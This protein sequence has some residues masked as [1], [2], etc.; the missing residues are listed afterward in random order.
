MSRHFTPRKAEGERHDYEYTRC[1]ECGHTYYDPIDADYFGQAIRTSDEA[2]GFP[3]VLTGLYALSPADVPLLAKA[4]E[5]K[6]FVWEGA[7]EQ[8]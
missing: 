3:D 7:D 5:G 4:G 6:T 2:F 8:G 1:L